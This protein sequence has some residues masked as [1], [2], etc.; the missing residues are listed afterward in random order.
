RDLEPVAHTDRVESVDWFGAHWVVETQELPLHMIDPTGELRMLG[1]PPASERRL[2]L[3]IADTVLRPGDPVIEP[4]GHRLGVS[5]PVPS[6]LGLRS[7]PTS[8]RAGDAV[9]PAHEHC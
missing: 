7:R 4:P 2:A 3:Q 1:E 5:R 6:R 9:A 8:S